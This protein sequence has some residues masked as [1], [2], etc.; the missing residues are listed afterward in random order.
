MLSFIYSLVRDY[1]AE[2]GHR[3]N[4]LHL[5]VDHFHRLRQDFVDP[6]DIEAIIKR[7][8]MEFS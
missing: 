8:G 7:L 4:V 5:N 2:H 3:P 1:E 6:G